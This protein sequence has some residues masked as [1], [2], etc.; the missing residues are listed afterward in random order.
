MKKKIDWVTIVVVGWFALI[1]SVALI[2]G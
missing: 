1:A 2:F